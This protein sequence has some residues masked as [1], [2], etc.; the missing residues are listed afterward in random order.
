MDHLPYPDNP[1]MPPVLV[2][3]V[4]D[5]VDDYDALGFVN[6][7]I[8][9]GWM[10][11][12]YQTHWCECAPDVATV[13]AQ[14]WLYFGLLYEFFGTDFLKSMFVRNDTLNSQDVI[15]TQNLPCMLKAWFD[16]TSQQTENSSAKIRALLLDA[17]RYS[18]PLE[19]LVPS[20]RTISLSIKVLICSLGAAAGVID[21]GIRRNEAFNASPSLLLE[22]RMLDLNWCP[23]WVKVYSGRYSVPT[24]NYLSAITRTTML[25]DHRTCNPS[26]CIAH[27]VDMQ[28]YKTRHV[29]EGC[30]CHFMGPDISKINASI[31]EGSVPLI[32]CTEAP[33]GHVFLD[34]IDA[35]PGVEY[36]AISHVWSGGLGNPNTNAL[37][38]CQLKR[39]TKRMQQ[40]SGVESEWFWFRLIERGFKY[41]NVSF[42]SRLKTFFLSWGAA[43]N[44]PSQ[45]AFWLDTLCVP[46][47]PEHI[48][49]RRKAINQMAFIYAG[50]DR[51]LVLD[52]E[53]Q[54][55]AKGNMPNQQIC[56]Y[57]ASCAWRSRCWPY[58]EGRLAKDRLY[59][60]EDDLYHHSAGLRQIRRMS[61]DFKKGLSMLSDQALVHSALASFW[62]DMENVKNFANEKENLSEFIETWNSL[63][64]RSTTKPEDL[65]GILAVL[66]GL[67]SREILSLELK[68]RMKAIFHSQA[69][70]PISLLYLPHHET[71]VRDMKN[72]WIPQYPSGHLTL[73]YG[74]M[75]QSIGGEALIFSPADSLSC[76]FLVNPAVAVYPRFCLIDDASSEKI[77]IQFT[78][79]H[80]T[81]LGSL[82]GS[83]SVCYL[84]YN[85]M[86]EF[87]PLSTDSS[88]VGARFYVSRQDQESE[89]HLIYDCPL[90][91]TYKRPLDE[92]GDLLQ[93]HEYPEVHGQRTSSNANF[94]LE[95][96]TYIQ[97]HVHK[98]A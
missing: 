75:K 64:L 49:L 30:E 9:R 51:V 10:S 53:L 77:W 61:R 89:L 13:R 84:L 50:A 20:A 1:A 66:L 35:D 43:S 37:P 93:L 65:H 76:G 14:T 60:L 7:P 15:T 48:S 12:T 45:A 22:E 91:Y 97:L 28:H 67:S 26:Q 44:P 3:Y 78:G 27:N 52:P 79:S 46:A 8:R 21:S 70:L 57:L 25:E 73:E 54:N 40:I 16:K 59:L 90:K 72:Q 80:N 33:S 82:Y 4:C 24:I 83:S 5:G 18:K 38:E 87:Q 39:L 17:E 81:E 36:T 32:R 47:A 19:S 68:E 42:R 2:P 55:I 11:V 58:Q 96:G 94:F 92:S 41:M 69:L 34:V 98:S 85:H 71:R 74:S 88:S 63:G 31:Q 62:E 56:A 6:F 23:Y 95:C 86:A 29:T